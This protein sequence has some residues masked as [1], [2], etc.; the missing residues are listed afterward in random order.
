MEKTES[1]VEEYFTEMSKEEVEVFNYLTGEPLNKISKLL[2][3]QKEG[4]RA[5]LFLTLLKNALQGHKEK[6]LK[7]LT[8]AECTFVRMYLEEERRC[9]LFY[10]LI[11]SS[12]NIS[13]VVC[14]IC[15]TFSENKHTLVLTCSNHEGKGFTVNNVCGSRQ[16]C[17][18]FR[19]LRARSKFCPSSVNNTEKTFLSQ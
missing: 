4:I 12:A 18:D 8:T 11:N 17:S 13:G 10:A 1:V 9:N 7:P 14:P 3:E 2:S 5:L 6:D 16:C 19:D 15:G